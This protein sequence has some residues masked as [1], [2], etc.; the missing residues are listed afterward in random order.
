MVYLS[1]DFAMRQP[2]DAVWRRLLE[3]HKTQPKFG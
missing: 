1:L 3:D 2:L